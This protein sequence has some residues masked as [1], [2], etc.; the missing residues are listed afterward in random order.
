M[1]RSPALP[2]AFTSWCDPAACAMCAPS[3]DR[4]ASAGSRSTRCPSVAGHTPTVRPPCSSDTVL[5]PTRRSRL[6][7]PNSRACLPPPRYDDEAC[8]SLTRKPGASGLPVWSAP[9]HPLSVLQT[10]CASSDHRG[11]MFHRLTPPRR[12][13]Q[14][15]HAG[16][17]ASDLV[18]ASPRIGTAGAQRMRR[19]TLRVAVL[20]VGTVLAAQPLGLVPSAQADT[21]VVKVTTITGQ[22]R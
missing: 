15:Q 9:P 5:C 3:R 13:D 2:P 20:T 11:Q 6:R 19:R 7:W 18:A 14:P 8:G 12:Y 1:S 16:A 17:T 10:G 21:C 4:R 22:H